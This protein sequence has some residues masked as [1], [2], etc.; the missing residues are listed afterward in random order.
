MT[1]EEAL[2][3]LMRMC[4]PDAYPELTEAELLEVLEDSARPAAWVAATAYV[5]G[6]FLTTA[7]GRLQ[8]CVRAGTSGAAEPAWPGAEY[9]ET[10]AGSLVGVRTDEGDGAPLW[11]DAGVSQPAGY[12][13]RA[14]AHLGWHRKAERAAGVVDTSDPGRSIK[15]SQ[16]FDHCM[17]KAA[18]YEPL[19]FV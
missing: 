18:S 2:A 8:Q 14:A 3:R 1:Q 17:R 6:D 10:L 9:S 11:E 12:D 7:A 15:A 4:P 19:G 13:L 5:V 16:A